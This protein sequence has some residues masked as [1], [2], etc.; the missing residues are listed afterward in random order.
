[1]SGAS[2]LKE[3]LTSALS[4]A[5]TQVASAAPQPPPTT[6]TPASLDTP[7]SPEAAPQE[8]Q[9]TTAP[10]AP[11]I[12]EATWRAALAVSKDKFYADRVINTCNSGA[13][14]DQLAP[15]QMNIL[16]LGDSHGP[17][18]HN[19]MRAVFP[20]AKIIPWSRA[21]CIISPNLEAWFIARNLPDDEHR[22]GCLWMVDRVFNNKPMLAG[23]DLVVLNYMLNPEHM[24]LME[25]TLQYIKAN[26][27]KARII[28]FGNAPWYT[29]DLP[30]VARVRRLDPTLTVPVD[31]MN[32]LTWQMDATLKP[33][34]E[35]Y[36]A[37]F[38]SKAAYFCPGNA[39]RPFTRDGSSLASYDIH[40]LS[41]KAA[42]DFGKANKAAIQNAAGR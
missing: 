6:A 3:P 28:L 11:A 25:E 19:I 5:A 17:D 18:G 34:A 37:T 29:Q 13:E 16:V 7:A 42:E 23:V 1:V 40:H 15:G 32:P 36:G 14:C 38:I 26:S 21:G 30:D 33:L 8:Q 39:C 24:N 9:P 35:K 10:A 41:L 4:P 12:P 2:L 22:K 20:T 31:F 27:P